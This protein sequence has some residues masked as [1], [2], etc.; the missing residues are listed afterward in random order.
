MEVL[1]TIDLLPFSLAAKAIIIA[2][3]TTRLDFIASSCLLLI[4][5]S[6]RQRRTSIAPTIH[7]SIPTRRSGPLL[8]N[9]SEKAVPTIRTAMEAK[10]LQSP[11]YLALYAF[12]ACLEAQAVAEGARRRM[13]L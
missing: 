7:T 3:I 4:L 1:K 12:R 5:N 10:V 11:A 2:G 13:A 8:L 9:E 6:F